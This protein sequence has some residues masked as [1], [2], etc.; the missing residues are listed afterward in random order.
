M[1]LAPRKPLALQTPSRIRG[2]ILTGCVA[3][4]LFVALWCAIF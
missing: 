2:A 4:T 3:G 1:I